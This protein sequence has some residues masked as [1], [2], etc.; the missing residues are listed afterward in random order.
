MQT[1]YF[2]R[3]WK[4]LHF[5]PH[6]WENTRW[7]CH[8]WQAELSYNAKRSDSCRCE[9]QEACVVTRTFAEVRGHRRW[10]SVRFPAGCA[11]K[12]SAALLY[13]LCWTEITVT[14]AVLC[15]DLLTDDNSLCVRLWIW[16]N[17]SRT[18]S[19]PL[20]NA[21]KHTH[22]ISMDNSILMHHWIWNEKE[23]KMCIVHS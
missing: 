4:M 15:R 10:G 12:Q 20:P 22:C 3:T 17:H 6:W 9:S 11:L 7:K 16:Q 14:S 2:K 18:L 1:I 21:H 5:E 13:N 23:V 8:L 19:L